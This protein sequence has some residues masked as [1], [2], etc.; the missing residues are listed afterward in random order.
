MSEFLENGD[1]GPKAAEGF[2]FAVVV[3][4]F[5]ADITEALFEGV[6][7]TLTAHGA[8]SSNISVYEVPGAFELP[9][10]VARLSDERFDA[11]ICLAAIIKG[12]TPHFDYLSSSVAHGIQEVAAHSGTPAIWGVLTCEQREHAVARAGGN[13]GNKGTEAAIAAIKMAKLFSLI[14]ERHPETASSI[15]LSRK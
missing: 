15:D 12:E 8:S 5:N 14:P 3:S 1:L 4:R 13:K 11:I 10:T 6:Q 7:T 2:R 9:M